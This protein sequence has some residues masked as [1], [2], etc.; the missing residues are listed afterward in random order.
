M[1]RLNHFFEAWKQKSFT[2]RETV[3][4]EE[5]ERFTSTSMKG[6]SENRGGSED[7]ETRSLKM[8]K[9]REIMKKRRE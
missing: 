9:V 1:M 3:S 8:D 5:D 4:I 2:I 7:M 6:R